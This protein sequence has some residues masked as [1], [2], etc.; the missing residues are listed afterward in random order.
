MENS[1]D[2]RYYLEA[3]RHFKPHTLSEGEEKVVNLKN[4]TGADALVNLYN[5]IT[6]RYVFKLQVKGEVRELTRGQLQ[7]Y[8]Q[9]PD[10]DLRAQATPAG[11]RG[12]E[13][14]R[15]EGT[16]RAADS[17]CRESWR[18]RG[19]ASS[20]PTHGLFQVTWQ[21]STNRRCGVKQSKRGWRMV[22]GQG[23]NRTLDTKIVSLD[24]WGV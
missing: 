9:G 8:T 7:P 4:V 11:P 17:S 6:N 21:L 13:H 18:A 20:P 14:L 10:P 22:G 3:M 15:C 1:G 16:A 24:A 23:V 5:A 12:V 2:Y 19:Q